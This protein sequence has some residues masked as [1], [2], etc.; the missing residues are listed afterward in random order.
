MSGE[1]PRLFRCR[2]ITDGKTRCGFEGV[3]DELADHARDTGHKLCI[4]CA[5]SLAN[6]EQQTCTRCVTRAR[7]DLT[8]IADAYATLPTVVES[9]GYHQ[10]RLPGGD[11]LVMLADGSVEGGGPDDWLTDPTPVIAVLEANERDWRHT[12]GHPPAVDIAT[13]TGCIGYL[14]MW[15]PTAARTH[16]GFDDYTR[17]I[18]QLRVRLQH[19]AGVA[20]DPLRAPVRCFDCGGQLE[21]PYDA[22]GLTEDWKCR[23]CRRTYTHEAYF[24]ALQAGVLMSRDWVP[25]R[26]AAV[27]ARQPVQRVRNWCDRGLV[28]VACRVYEHVTVVWWPDV[29]AKASQT[30]ER[31][32]A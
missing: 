6:D 1:I 4:V 2:H 29:I 25:I 13:V 23:Q 27:A 8:D 26:A 19:V 32:S 3:Q 28:R 17:E 9:S 21:R 10:A 30:K 15:L 24:L 12:F 16:P 7:Q 14:T 18:R 5:H 22:H 31:I 11:A 20:D